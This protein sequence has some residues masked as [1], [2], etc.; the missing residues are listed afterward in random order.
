MSDALRTNVNDLLPLMEP[1]AGSPYNYNHELFGG[2]QDVQQYSDFASG[3]AGNEIVDWVIVELRDVAD[4]VTVIAS[5]S[6]LIQ[7][8]GDIVDVDGQSTLFIPGVEAGDYIV[9]VDHRNHLGVRT[10]VALSLSTTPVAYDFTT[11]AEQAYV[12]GNLLNA[13]QRDL[14]SGV[15]GL[16]NGDANLNDIVSY[17]GPSN[18]RIA[19][20]LRVGFS[21][22]SNLINDV[23]EEFDANMN[24]VTAYNGPSNDRI[25]ILLAVGFTTPSNIISRHN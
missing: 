5:K 14:G 8:D 25:S 4:S 3:G 7:K 16:W 18:D 19:V 23:Y 13:P 10:P 9:A 2:L 6:A 15:F 12:D 1:Y 21:T 22:P 11:A 20:L 24:G 17:N